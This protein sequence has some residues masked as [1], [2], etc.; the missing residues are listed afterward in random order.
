MCLNVQCSDLVNIMQLLHPVNMRRPSSAAVRDIALQQLTAMQL[1]EEEAGG[2][3]SE[4]V[5]SRSTSFGDRCRSMSFPVPVEGIASIGGN[6]Q[7]GVES[8][9]NEIIRLRCQIARLEEENERLRSTDARG[10]R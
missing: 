7:L 6:G 2:A 1:R 10:S 5:S 4:S 9:E 3:Q 8:S